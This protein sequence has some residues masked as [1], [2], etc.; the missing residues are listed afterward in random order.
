MPKSRNKK[1]HKKRVQNYLNKKKAAE[2]KTRKLLMEQYQKMEE[3]RAK[4]IEAQK[5]GEIIENNDIVVD[6]DDI[7]VDE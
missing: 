6:V 4:S 2:N 7:E 5:T 3:E 1:G